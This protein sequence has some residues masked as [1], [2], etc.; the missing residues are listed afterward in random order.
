MLSPTYEITTA[1]SHTDELISPPYDI[2]IVTISYG[3]VTMSSVWD[4]M[5]SKKNMGWPFYAAVHVQQC[6]QQSNLKYVPPILNTYMFLVSFCSC[7]WPIH[8]SMKS[9]RKMYLE[10][11]RQALQLHRSDQQFYCLTK[12]WL[13]LEIWRWDWMLMHPTMNCKFWITSDWEKR[14][15]N[16]LLAI[17]YWNYHWPWCW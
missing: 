13:I 17:N 14:K 9:R 4:S 16:N 5:M 12:A 10:Q 8:W 15:W 3:R 7:L 6:R 2:A 1:L 11:H